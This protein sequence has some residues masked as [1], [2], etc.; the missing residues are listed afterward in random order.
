MRADFFL[1][2]NRDDI[3]FARELIIQIINLRAC[4]I[5]I[6]LRRDFAAIFPGYMYTVICVNRLIGQS[7]SLVPLI[8]FYELSSGKA[9]LLKK[10]QV[11]NLLSS[12]S[13]KKGKN[14][15]IAANS[16]NESDHAIKEKI[17]LMRISVNRR[18]KRSSEFQ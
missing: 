4:A 16:F 17:E 3:N 14:I 2:L 13:L 7:P 6:N 12:I 15:T 11:K 1:S 10:T 18:C 9:W 5:A 8:V